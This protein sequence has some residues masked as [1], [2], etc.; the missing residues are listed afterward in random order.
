MNMTYYPFMKKMA[1]IFNFTT[2]N[3]STLD[4]L[5]DAIVVDKYLGRPMPP[6][7]SDSDYLNLKHLTIWYDLFRLNFDLAKAFNT[8]VIKRIIEDFDDR[9]N[10]LNSK[11]LKWTAL[12]GH[13]TNINCLLNSL[14]ISSASCI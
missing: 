2:L 1:D 8:N 12:S 5:H 9:I 7:F 11:P 14:N 6:S 3:F 4:G 13:D 10:N